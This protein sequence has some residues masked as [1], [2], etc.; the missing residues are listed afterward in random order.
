[1]FD[2]CKKPKNRR[3]TTDEFET[4]LDICKWLNRP[5]RTYFYDRPFYPWLPPAPKI[6]QVNFDLGFK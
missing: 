4:E 5:P 6:P 3:F 1:M 2:D